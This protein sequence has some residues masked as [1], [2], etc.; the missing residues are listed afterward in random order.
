MEPKDELT[1]VSRSIDDSCSRLEK[2]A[3]SNPEGARLVIRE[4]MTK[5]EM[6]SAGINEPE[7]REYEPTLISERNA[8]TLLQFAVSDPVVIDRLLEKCRRK[9]EDIIQSDLDSIT[10]RIGDRRY[11]KLGSIIGPL[12]GRTNQSLYPMDVAHLLCLPDDDR[13]SAVYMNHYFNPFVYIFA[14]KDLNTADIVDVAARVMDSKSNGRL[15]FMDVARELRGVLRRSFYT[16]E[17]VIRDT[18]V[19][20]MNGTYSIDDARSL[21]E[22]LEQ[23]TPLHPSKDSFEV[24]GVLEC[25]SLGC[26]QDSSVIVL[27]DGNRPLVMKRADFP[28]H[29]L[30]LA[31]IE[32]KKKELDLTG[33]IFDYQYRWGV[34]KIDGKPIEL[35]E[36]EVTKSK[37]VQVFDAVYSNGVSKGLAST[38]PRGYTGRELVQRDI[39]LLSRQHL[40]QARVHQLDELSHLSY[41]AAMIRAGYRRERLLDAGAS[42]YRSDGIKRFIVYPPHKEKDIVSCLL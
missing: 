27:K 16:C 32:Q 31:V 23:Y 18:L 42:V 6:V 11:L 9:D 30:T 2:M 25:E 37:L 24:Q 39:P 10:S 29:E 3:G 15:G 26:V 12:Q 40:L 41:K 35:S 17:D 14:D 8:N 21:I 34:L 20:D 36:G 5:L 28:M 33:S 1:A 19:P 22:K 7:A 4:G 13:F 38:F